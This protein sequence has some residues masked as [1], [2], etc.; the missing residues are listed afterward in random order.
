MPTL[1]Q[2]RQPLDSSFTQPRRRLNGEDLVVLI[3]CAVVVVVMTLGIIRF[4]REFH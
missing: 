2:D 4:L 1:D 3:S